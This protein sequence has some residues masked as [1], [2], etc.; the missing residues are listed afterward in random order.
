M[1][2]DTESYERFGIGGNAVAECRAIAPEAHR[3]QHNPVFVGAA[4][5][6]NEGAMHVSV[7]SNNEAD[8]HLQIVILN[9]QQRVRGEQGLGRTDV[10]AFWQGQRLRHG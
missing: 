6:Q 4:A 1:L 9:M 8:A 10:S 3:A 5:V 2:A 7:G